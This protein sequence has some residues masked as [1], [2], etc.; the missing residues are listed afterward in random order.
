MPVT[1]NQGA[2]GLQRL[3][4]LIS[5]ADK[6]GVKLLLTLTNNWNPVRTK[7]G[8]TFARRTYGR[9]RRGYLCD[10]YGRYSFLCNYL[11]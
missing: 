10:D 8:I 3:D 9:L 1:I 2:D 6:Y 11:D 5:T 4:K 7:S